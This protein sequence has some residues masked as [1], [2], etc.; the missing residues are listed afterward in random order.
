MIPGKGD[1]FS[2]FFFIFYLSKCKLSLSNVLINVHL[3]SHRLMIIN[4]LKINK[5]IHL[6]SQRIATPS[7]DNS[8]AST[9]EDQLDHLVAQP[10]DD[11]D[12]REI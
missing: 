12:Y 5:N 2:L 9:P 3:S 4:N 8:A 11:P 1:F 7:Q 10:D 6:A